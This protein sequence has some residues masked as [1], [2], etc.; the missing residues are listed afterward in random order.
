[1]WF[2]DLPPGTVR[3]PATGVKSKWRMTLFPVDAAA[4]GWYP[5]AL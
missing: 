3:S 5:P 2:A 4:P 1:M